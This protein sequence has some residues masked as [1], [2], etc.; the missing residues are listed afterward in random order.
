MPNSRVGKEGGSSQI[1]R[2]AWR[3]YTSLLTTGGQ[4]A[5]LKE[6]LNIS[7]GGQQWQKAKALVVAFGLGETG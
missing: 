4:H 5:N 2:N 1:A 6:T 7:R 3:W